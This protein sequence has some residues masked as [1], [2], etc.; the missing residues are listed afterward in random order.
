MLLK[1]LRHRHGT[2][3]EEKKIKSKEVQEKRNRQIEN[4]FFQFIQTFTA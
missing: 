3:P 2:P 1:R 4:N